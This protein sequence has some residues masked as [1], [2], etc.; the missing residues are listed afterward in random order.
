ME[1]LFQLFKVKLL[2]P[3]YVLHLAEMILVGSKYSVWVK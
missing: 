3:L 1:L 2:K